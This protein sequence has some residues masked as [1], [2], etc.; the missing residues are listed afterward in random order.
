MTSTR[1]VVN[2]L[3]LIIYLIHFQAR[4]TTPLGFWIHSHGSA[5]LTIVVTLHFPETSTHRSPDFRNQKFAYQRDWNAADTVGQHGVSSDGASQAMGQ[6]GHV[7][8]WK[9]RDPLR[10]SRN[11]PFCTCQQR[12]V[13]P[14]D[15]QTLSRGACEI[16]LQDVGQRVYGPL[17]E[18]PLLKSEIR[19]TADNK[20]RY[21]ACS[22]SAAPAATS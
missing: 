19:Q 14:N 8:R 3:I 5:E 9:R 13:P 7:P 1:R 20:S 17:Q 15:E 2:L 11:S 21:L 16:N 18:I 22:T 4:T 10:V 6:G 12:A